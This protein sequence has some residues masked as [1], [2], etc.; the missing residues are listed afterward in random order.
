[1]SEA[2]RLRFREAS[3]RRVQRVLTQ[4]HAMENLSNKSV[5][6]YDEKDVETIGKAIEE[7]LGRLVDRLSIAGKGPLRFDW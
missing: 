3:K 7:A 1:M 5:Y 4:L 2:K 6:E